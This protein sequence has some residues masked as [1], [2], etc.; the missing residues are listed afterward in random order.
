MKLR[1]KQKQKITSQTI[2]NS[3]ALAFL[4]TGATICPK[5]FSIIVVYRSFFDRFKDVTKN[6]NAE[7]APRIL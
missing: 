2:R 3:S 7:N 5:F 1:I 4:Y 6:I